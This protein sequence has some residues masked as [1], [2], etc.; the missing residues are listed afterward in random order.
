M[1]GSNFDDDEKKTTGGRNGYGAKLANIFSSEFKVECAD[2]KRGK[3]FCQT[4]RD[5]MKNPGEPIIK[6]MTAAQVKKGDYVK[7]SFSPDLTRFKMDSLDEDTV[8]LL[9]KRAYDIAG[10]MANR[11]GKKLVVTLNGNKIPVKKFENYLALYRGIEAPTAYEMVDIRWEVG[12]SVSD[13][14]FQQVSF[15]NSINTSKGGEHVNYIADQ[16]AKRLATVLVRKSKGGTIV[17]PAQIKNY[18]NVFV[19]CLIENPAFDSQTKEFLTTKKGKFGSKC[20]L[21]EAFLKKVEKSGI[22]DK[23]LAMAKFREKEALGKKSGKKTV[24][25]TG[26]T[27]LDDANFAGTGKSKDCTLLLTEG[28]SAK[29][30]AMSGISVVGRDYYGVFPLKGKPLNVREATNAQ[31]SCCCRHHQ[32]V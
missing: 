21:S 20:E 19:N 30:L 11:K 4:F 29:S 14:T 22:V 3:S 6:N 28:D 8:A 23:I 10:S 27:K 17:K 9:S 7:I 2:S 26:I 31:V 24:K 25:L 15:V 32:W 18:L 5:N 12:V 13:G 16:V 1:T